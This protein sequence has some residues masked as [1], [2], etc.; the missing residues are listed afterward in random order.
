MTYKTIS[1]LGN[2]NQYN[3]NQAVKINHSYTNGLIEIY[4]DLINTNEMSIISGEK[5]LANG[6]L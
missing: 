6:L 1:V 2:K 4:L 5:V 3:W